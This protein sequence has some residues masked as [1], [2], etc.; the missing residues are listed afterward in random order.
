MDTSTVPPE[1]LLVRG[2]AASLE[3][4]FA[5]VLTNAAQAST[6][7]GRVTVSVEANGGPQ[8][9]I[10]VR[11][12]G[13]GMTAEVLARVG[14]PLFSTKPQG[15]GLGLAIARRIAAAHGG[16]VVLDSTVGAGTT[17]AIHLPR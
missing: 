5:N 4:L 1:P 8:L 10:R 16:T 2:D 6:N 14:E 7:G 15:T 3:Q 13:P 9:S 12:R 17:V 11:D